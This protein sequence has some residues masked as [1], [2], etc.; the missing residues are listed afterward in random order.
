MLNGKRVIAVIPARGG[1]KSVPGKNIRPLA[2]TP[3]IAWSIVIAKQVQ[4]IDRV[5][6]STDDDKIA[7]VSRQFAAEVYP[8]PVELATDDAL[9]IDALKDLVCTLKAEQ[10]S[11]EVLVILEPTCPFRS[12][13]DVRECL[14]FFSTDEYDCAATFCTAELNPH[15][16]W[17]INGRRPEVFIPGAIPWLPRQQLPEAYQLN[18]AVYAVRI[19]GLMVSSQSILFGRIGAVK[20]PRERSID[21]NDPIDFLLAEQFAV[22]RSHA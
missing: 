12:V 10:E 16:A 18:G 2:G 1:S 7:D 21:I 20:M 9:V 4:E 5:I 17:R 3:L 8:R 11:A 14:S 19:A 13:A 6:V 22:E 15:R